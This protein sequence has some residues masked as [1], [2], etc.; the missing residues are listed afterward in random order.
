MDVAERAREEG[1]RVEELETP[2]LVLDVE[3]ARATPR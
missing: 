3:V 2:A 1:R